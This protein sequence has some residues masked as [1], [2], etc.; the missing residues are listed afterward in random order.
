MSIVFDRG[1]AERPRGHG[2]LYFRS[3]SDPDEI[4]VTYLVVLPVTVDVSKYVP[5]FLL[6]QVGDLT[7]KDLSAFAF[8]PAPELLGG[9][10]SLEAMAAARDDDVLFAGSI[11]SSDVPSSML[12]VNEAMQEYAEMYAR[13]IEVPEPDAGAGE[14]EGAGP[15]VSEVLY[16]LMSDG[17]KLGEL[18]RLI[19]RFRFSVEGSD[20]SLVAEAEE[21]INILA[22]HLPE[23]LDISQLVQ[24]VRASG[25]QGARLA[26]LYLQ[27]C[28]L[29]VSE[30]YA[31]LGP[32]EAQIREMEQEASGG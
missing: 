11:S 29:L 2:L 19:G 21:D 14:G 6:N 17:D 1:S 18:T 5:P 16:G 20:P 9:Y 15:G 7:S 25:S 13:L 28:Y 32:V 23:K 10:H 24:A 8:P 4:W 30:D 31:K 26:E 3:S 27:R 22:A 12:A